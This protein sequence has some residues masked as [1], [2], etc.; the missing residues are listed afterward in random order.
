MQNIFYG[1]LLFSNIFQE[2]IC[3]FPFLF[4]SLGCV[5][6]VLAS[7]PLFDHD[8]VV[9]HAPGFGSLVILHVGCRSQPCRMCFLNS[10]VQNI[11]TVS[12]FWE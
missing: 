3:L 4:K 8:Y 2:N 5:R 12:V 10:F 7:C 1:L 11:S 6:Y 9:L